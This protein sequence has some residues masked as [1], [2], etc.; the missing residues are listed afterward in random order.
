MKGNS[1]PKIDKDIL[2]KLYLK[3]NRCEFV[4]TDPVQF[5]W[6][7]DDP[8]DRE[9]V[10][11]ISSSLAYGRVAQILK[12]VSSVLEKMPGPARFLRNAALGSLERAFDGF[13]HRFTTGK[14]LAAMLYGAKL[15]IEKY[16]SLNH[17][18][19]AS[20]SDSDEAILPALEG[21]VRELS[22]DEM[23]GPNYLLPL[24]SRGSACKRSN[25]FLRWM[26]REDEIDPGCWR[27]VSTMK[28]IIPL[29]THMAGICRALGI[30]E[31]KQ[32]DMK[33]AIEI[34]DFFRD[35]NPEDPVRYDFALTRLGIL[36]GT[37]LPSFVTRCRTVEA[38]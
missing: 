38:A 27:G 35:V 11:L 23:I 19:L 29:D 21:F 7:Y 12:S 28:L 24:P 31:R 17:C 26:V 10:G 37:D 14:G 9:I 25:L 32:A 6:N 5:L 20:L 1:R 2:E 8:Q 22:A 30:T 15:A 18:F 36:D 13:K 33:T 3:Y 34:T 4:P 16:G